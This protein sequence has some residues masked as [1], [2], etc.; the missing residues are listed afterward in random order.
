MAPQFIGLFLWVVFFDQIPGETVGRTRI[1]WPVGGAA[2]GGLL[3][4]L[5]LYRTPALW[6]LRSRRPLAVV[7]SRTFGVEGATVV[8]GLLLALVQ[9]VWLALGVY[10]ATAL[11]LDGLERLGLLDPSYRNPIRVGSAELPGGLFVFTSLMWT[12][13]S[14]L[15]GRYLMR[16][17]AALM[18][19]YPVLPA[20]LLGTTAA[21]AMKG[22]PDYQV[23]MNAT[24][25]VASGWPVAA[26]V[27]QMILG[28]FSASALV[29][30]DWGAVA[31]AERDV[32]LGGWVGVAFA[33]WVVATLSVLCVAGAYTRYGLPAP[34][35]P[36]SVR[37]LAFT[38]A[39]RTL[40]GGRT[41]GFMLIGFS[42][43]ALAPAC[44]AAS[45]LSERLNVLWPRVSRTRW[46]LSAAGVA[47][48][49]ALSGVLGRLLPVF[50][51]VGAVFAPVVGA[52]AADFLRSRGAW[53]HPRRGVNR[54]GVMAWV[55]GLVI[56]LTPVVGPTLGARDLASVQPAALFAFLAAFVTYLALAVLG[57]ESPTEEAIGPGPREPAASE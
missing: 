2:V 18:Q 31:R 27:V 48:V 35:G 42:L 37:A 44:Y 7:A 46:T 45:F 17:I 15:T 55:V 14:A 11:G 26:V 30:A 47:W 10:Y 16:V 23:A 34:P 57:F 1:L 3:A 9:V 32:S 13:A 43:V 49:L 5:L 53:T 56:G 39:L 22:L 29:C 25:G 20:L 28:F 36:G 38:H 4:Y 50:G 52:M 51:V 21:V 41:S 12:L 40:I 54:P 24:S 8:P 19:V 33:S 6:G